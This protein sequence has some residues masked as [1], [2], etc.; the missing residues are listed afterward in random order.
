[1]LRMA[2]APD[3]AVGIEAGR[4]DS[5]LGRPPGRAL[6]IWCALGIL[7]ALVLLALVAMLAGRTAAS[8]AT[9][10]LPVLSRQPCIVALALL[11]GTFAAVAAVFLRRSRASDH[12]TP[13]SGVQ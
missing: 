11:P 7:A 3:G 1:M 2:K 10:A 12:E 4:V 5:L 13:H 8:S 6:P 9:L